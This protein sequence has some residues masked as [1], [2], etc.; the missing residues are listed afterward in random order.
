[1]AYQNAIQFWKDFDL[2]FFQK[3]LDEEASDIARR[4][5]E[6]DLSVKKLVE[7]SREFKRS[8]PED[9]RKVVSPLLKAF[10]GEVD[11]LTKRSTSCETMFLNTYR[12]LIEIPNPVPLFEQALSQQN[13]LMKM[14]DVELENKKLRETLDEY[15]REFAQVKNQGEHLNDVIV[16]S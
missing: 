5:D 9:V 10:Q 2:Q 11:A 1:M 13:K 12:K 7:L 8:T 16:N 14:Q 6:S 15:T 4:Q 3:N